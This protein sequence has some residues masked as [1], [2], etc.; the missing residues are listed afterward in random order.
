MSRRRTLRSH[1]LQARILRMAW[2]RR[3]RKVFTPDHDFGVVPS[4]A[5]ITER[6]RRAPE[7]KV[8]LEGLP[9]NDSWIRLQWVREPAAMLMAD[10]PGWEP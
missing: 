4:L 8:H 7:T 2:K 10:V 1:R 5:M 9:G 6:T 3:K